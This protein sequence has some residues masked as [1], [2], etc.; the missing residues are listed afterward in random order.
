MYLSIKTTST[1]PQKHCAIL[2]L[3]ICKYV[4]KIFVVK[5]R[6]DTLIHSFILHTRLLYFILRINLLFYT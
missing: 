1:T 2:I 3:T 5:N 4:F 6:F